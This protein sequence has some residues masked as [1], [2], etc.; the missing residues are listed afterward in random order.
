MKRP[1]VV[2]VL[3]LAGLPAAAVNKCVIDGRA[4]YQDAPCP[5][6][7]ETV[8]QGLQRRE[9]IEVWH[10]KLDRMQTRG[11]GLVQHDAPP[12]PPPPRSA[13]DEPPPR[14]GR[15]RPTPAYRAAEDDRLGAQTQRQNAASLQ[16]LNARLEAAAAAC[17]GKLHPLPWVGMRDE[18][19]RSCTL[20]ARFGGVQQI[21]AFEEGG[22]Q[23]RLYVFGRGEAERVYSVDGVITAIRP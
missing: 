9:R 20:H 2:A 17:G 7:G 22:V 18:T 21:V 1:L 16:A 3:A 12:P 8:A 6:A 11:V 4:V 19:F 15:W 10:G 13:D 23:M 14:L 5:E